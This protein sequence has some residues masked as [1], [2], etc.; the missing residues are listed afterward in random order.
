MTIN[1][2]P[3]WFRLMLVA[4]AVCVATGAILFAY[5][6]YARPTTL[7]L[8][9]GSLD[10]ETGKVASLIAGRLAANNA[11]VRIKVMNTGDVLESAKAFSENRAD[12]AVVRADVGDLE[13]A[14]TVALVAY[15]VVMIIAPPNS[16]Y[17]KFTDLKGKTIGAV[18]GEI[19]R[20]I[21]NALT[22]QYD[23]KQLDISFKNIAFADAREAIQSGNVGALLVVVPLARRYLS[24]INAIFRDQTDHSPTLLSIGSAAAIA[25]VEREYEAFSIPQGSLQGAPPVPDNDR[26]TLRTAVYL[27]ANSHIDPDI[28]AQLTREI[29]NARRDLVTEEPV[30][31]ALTAP[32]MDSGAYITVHPGA[33]EYYTGTQKDWLDKYANWIFLVP[34]VFGVAASIFAATLKFLQMGQTA[35]RDAML[36]TIYHLPRRIRSTKSE[37]ELQ[38]LE[39]EIDLMLKT[40]LS[41]S[42]AG[43]D[44]A[45]SVLILHSAAHRLDNLIHH[46]RVRLSG[47]AVSDNG[48][49]P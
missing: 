29:M 22:N 12:L 32:E 30:L 24:Y 31:A 49:L 14:R 36:N 25:D 8:A 42:A 16:P 21:V 40:Q 20:S 23:L 48:H 5:R 11:P 46:Q 2:I 17:T 1:S 43:S 18:G 7:T 45:T 10:G 28:I 44:S 4:A 19:N 39:D 15:S 3:F 38:E 9:V 47:I 35:A 34:I 33:A 41:T 27:V 13:N 37:S 6:Y 26:T